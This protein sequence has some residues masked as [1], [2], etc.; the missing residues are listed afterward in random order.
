MIDIK[1]NVKD[2]LETK[3]Y[4]KNLPEN[5]DRELVKNALNELA[6]NLQNRIKRRAPVGSTGWLRRSIMIEKPTKYTRTVIIHAYYAMAVEKGRSS[7]M[8]I[9]LE[10]IE[11]HSSTPDSPGHRV[12]NP[13]WIN[14]SNT[15][16][17]QPR[18]FIAPAMESFRP[19]IKEI[20]DKYLERA[21]K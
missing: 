21:L 14:L 4:F 2:L 17:S 13:T 5:I 10:F 9:P 16:A 18:P 3:R 6:V 19:K 20:L 12:S 8:V 15:R 7:Q 11:Q 1:V